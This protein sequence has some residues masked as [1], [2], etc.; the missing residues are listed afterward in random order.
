MLAA[1]PGERRFPRVGLAADTAI[2]IE[3]WSG[4]QTALTGKVTVLGAGG[5][6]VEL[7]NQ[8]P[9]GR[10]I[11]LRFKVPGIPNEIECGGL[12][13]DQIPGRGVGVEFTG[14]AYS[15]RDLVANSVTQSI[16][17]QA[18]PDCVTGTR[19]GCP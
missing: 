15:E 6:F 13:R 9:I 3:V 11:E 4:Q 18:C 17:A 19:S 7:S 8:V 1:T 14:L 16:Q 12:V 10:Y 2:P 5:A